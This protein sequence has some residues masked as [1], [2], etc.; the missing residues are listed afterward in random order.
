MWHPCA[1]HGL[2]QRRSGIVTG[3]VCPQPIPSWEPQFPHYAVVNGTEDAQPVLTWPF[4]S[5]RPGSSMATGD[6]VSDGDDGDTSDKSFNLVYEEDDKVEWLQVVGLPADD[7]A[8]PRHVSRC[9]GRPVL[10]PVQQ[11]NTF[12]YILAYAACRCVALCVCVVWC[13]CLCLCMCPLVL[14][15]PSPLS[16]VCVRAFAQAEAATQ[17]CPRLP[18]VRDCSPP[19]FAPPTRPR[20]AVG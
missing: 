5:S 2:R 13:V 10:V 14:L 7:S 11:N 3:N 19:H 4:A 20:H 15:T 6:G 18:R 12:E 9:Y 8:T 16:C 1:E 17:R